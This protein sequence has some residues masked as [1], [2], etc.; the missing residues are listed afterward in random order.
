MTLRIPRP[1]LCTDNGAMIAAVGAHVVQRWCVP[2]RSAPDRQPGH[3]GRLRARWIAPTSG[4]I[5]GSR[6]WHAMTPPPSADVGKEP[7]WPLRVRASSRT[8]R[9]RSSSLSCEGGADGGGRCDLGGAAGG[10]SGGD[11]VDRTAGA[12]GARRAGPAVVGVRARRARWCSGRR[13]PAVLV[14][15]PGDRA[16]PGAPA[17]RRAPRSIGSCCRRTT[18]GIDAWTMTRTPAVANVHRPAR[19]ARRFRR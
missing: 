1:G 18:S 16:E 12:A 7:Q 8:R 6:R 13:R 2:V 11:A 14:R 15:R 5:L 19:P 9:P 10:G 3:A 17:D 4:R